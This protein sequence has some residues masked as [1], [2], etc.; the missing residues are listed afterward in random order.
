MLIYVSLLCAI[1]VITYLAQFL[2]YAFSRHKVLGTDILEI[3]GL[4]LKDELEF[5][6]A[7]ESN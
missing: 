6:Q 4:P 7:V 1:V 5:E 3:I 2:A